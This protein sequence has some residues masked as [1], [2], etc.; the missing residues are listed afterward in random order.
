MQVDIYTMDMDIHL[1]W[2]S[3]M[4]CS[5]VF[6]LWNAASSDVFYHEIVTKNEVPILLYVPGIVFMKCCRNGNSIFCGTVS[7]IC[8]YN[9]K[10]N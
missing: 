4:S 6:G 8:V 3:I 7:L 1:F 5:F 9:L 10:N 2:V